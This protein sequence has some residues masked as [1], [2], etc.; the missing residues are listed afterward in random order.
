MSLLDSK[1]RIV[2]PALR[3]QKKSFR[4]GPA[5][6]CTYNVAPEKVELSRLT[7]LL[8]QSEDPEWERMELLGMR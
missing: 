1:K 6:Y 5:L 8:Y 4:S 2:S 3:G 7:V